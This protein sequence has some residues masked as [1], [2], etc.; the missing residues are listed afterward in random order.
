MKIISFAWTTPALLA[1]AKTVTRR[2]WSA[3]YAARFAP[4]EL[5]CAYDRNPRFKG[6]QVATIRI[7]SVV[8]G[9]AFKLPPED[10]EAEGFAYLSKRGA[11]VDGLTPEELWSDWNQGGA[12]H[13]WVVRFELVEVLPA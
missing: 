9:T 10:W 13:L 5:V 4:G 8:L 12:R 11:K 7:T 1:G 2:D 6:K 3:G